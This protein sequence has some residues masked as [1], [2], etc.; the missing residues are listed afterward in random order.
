VRPTYLPLTQNAVVVLLPFN[1]K[2]EAWAG[3]GLFAY[4]APL[5]RKLKESEACNLRVLAY[6]HMARRWR[7]SQNYQPSALV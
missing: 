6:L 5:A 3:I 7:A 1:W 4:G 2:S